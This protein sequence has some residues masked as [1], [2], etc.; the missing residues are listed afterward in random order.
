MWAG[1]EG[2]HALVC[3]CT[4]W[5][6][7][8]HRLQDVFIPCAA[9]VWGLLQVDGVVDTNGA[10]DSFAAGY[11]LAAAA[12]HPVPAAVANWAGERRDGS[13]QGGGAALNSWGG[14]SREG[15][16]CTTSAFMHWPATRARL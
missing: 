10:G 11:I 13:A 8:R 2:Q 4:R 1:R 14:V 5:C 3:C 16:T 12:G 6:T 15:I 9:L 7:L